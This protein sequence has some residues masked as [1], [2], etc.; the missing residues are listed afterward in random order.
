MPEKEPK[1]DSE[2]E[3]EVGEEGEGFTS[4]PRPEKI[5]VTLADGK[6]RTIQHMMATTFYDVSGKPMS[7]QEYLEKMCGDL[8]NQFGSE[9]ELRK[10]W[11]NPETRAMLLK[12]LEEQGYT[13]DR[14]DEIRRLIMADGSDLFDVLANVAY[15]HT[16]I[17][18]EERVETHKALLD[19]QYSDTLSAFID[20][21]LGQYIQEGV[22]ELARN[23]LP[24]LLE[25]KYSDIGKG[26]K[27]LGGVELVADTFADF[28]RYLYE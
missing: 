5:K 8:K 9:H 19:G 27:Q 18:R 21:V 17:T 6:F 10:L 11:G 1:P 28:Q 7:A 25:L 15:A 4:E 26:A 20:F 14:L 12:R 16:P 3:P 2:G 24:A 13:G 22:G 23:K